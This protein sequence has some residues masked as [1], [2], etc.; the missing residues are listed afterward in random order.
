ME[1]K[2][3]ES[4][5]H[6]IRMRIIQ[7]VLRKKETTVKDISDTLSDI[8]PASLYRHMNRL[9]AD[10]ILEVA[11]E[12]KVRGTLEK[13]YRIKLNPYEELAKI[14]ETRQTT[15]ILNI[16]YQ[17]VM[18]MLSDFECYFSSENVQ[19]EADGVGFSTAP[20]Y[21]NRNELIEMLSAIRETV[22]RY[23]N[24][25]PD[26]DRKLIKLSIISIPGTDQKDG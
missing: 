13:V 21:L 19:P 6:P 5:I 11:A 7:E 26:D 23:V 3:F 16:F 10:N 22:F 14:N 12:H 20:L 17:F 8:P 9:V 1:Y 15:A 25:K 18:S 24:N 4:M 2:I